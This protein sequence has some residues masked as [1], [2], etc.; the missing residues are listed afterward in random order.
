MADAEFHN[1]IAKTNAEVGAAKPKI[2]VS[3][4]RI[5]QNHRENG[6]THD[7]ETTNG[8]SAQNLLY[9]QSLE[10]FTPA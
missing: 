4:R 6:G 9:P 10:V 7:D 1:S 5:G 8:L 2:C 3:K